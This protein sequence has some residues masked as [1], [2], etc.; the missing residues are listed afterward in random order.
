M[1]AYLVQLLYFGNSCRIFLTVVIRNLSVGRTAAIRFLPLP[2]K[3]FKDFIIT[4]RKAVIY[5]VWC[6]DREFLRMLT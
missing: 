4:D 1:I 2:L 5:V 6:D 3:L